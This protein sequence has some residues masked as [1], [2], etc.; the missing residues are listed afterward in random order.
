MPVAK[1]YAEY[2][3]NGNPYTKNGRLY[4]EILYKGSP[5]E[6]RWYSNNEYARMYKETPVQAASTDT[7]PNLLV[8][9]K[10][11]GFDH[12]YITIF[13]GDQE[14]NNEWFKQSNA[15]YAVSWGWYV[16]STEQVPDNLPFGIEPVKLNWNLIGDKDGK[17]KS[18]DIVRSVVENLLYGDSTSEFIGSIGERL[19]FELKIKK[20][21]PLESIYGKA[22]TMHIMEDDCGN[23]F[24]WTT[25]AKKLLVDET[26]KMRG[27]IKDHKI[28]KG[29]NQTVLT[30]CTLVK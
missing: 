14:A 20:A 24:I 16:V 1:S 4:V 17:L 29:V 13:R 19:E 7:T 6:V 11:L 26:Y 8:V 12:G 27:T 3:I 25:S 5:K 18:S 10:A 30:R 22:T 9:K 2:P 23:C 28:Y 21:I 15:R